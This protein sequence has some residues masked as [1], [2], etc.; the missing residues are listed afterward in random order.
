M[1]LSSIKGRQLASTRCEPR[2][3]TLWQ[4]LDELAAVAATAAR[5]RDRQSHILQRR[6]RL[7]QCVHAVA[8]RFFGRLAVRDTLGEVRE[9]DE[10][11][12]AFFSSQGANFEWISG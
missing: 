9:R 7:R 12:T 2:M 11:A 8:D 4:A 5:L 3:G 10:I 1:S 6:N